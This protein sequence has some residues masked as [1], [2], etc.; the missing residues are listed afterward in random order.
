MTLT[1][2]LAL[3]GSVVAIIVAAAGNQIASEFRAWSP[4]LVER[5]IQLAVRR[6]P[7]ELR[8]RM[9][10]E[11]RAFIND[12]PGQLWQLVRAY[13]LRKGA[14]RIA[15]DYSASS[16]APALRRLERGLSR[17]FGILALPG[18]LATAYAIMITLVLLRR[19]VPNAL[20]QAPVSLALKLAK[21]ET[22]ITFKEYREGF[23]TVFRLARRLLRKD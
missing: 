5:W 20:L 8:E 12:T 9:E 16:K 6:V 14:A 22:I 15:Q 17:A 11:W 4:T 23:R 1:I 21:G 10:E 3:A 2:I 19:E 13:G 18:G 7:E